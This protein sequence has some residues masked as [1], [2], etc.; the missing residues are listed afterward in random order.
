M[1]VKSVMKTAIRYSPGFITARFCGISSGTRSSS[2]RLVVPGWYD[3]IDNGTDTHKMTAN[4]MYHSLARCRIV[5]D[6][7]GYCDYAHPLF[8][9]YTSGN[10]WVYCTCWWH[11]AKVPGH[12][13]TQCWLNIHCFGPISYRNITVI[14]K[15]IRKRDSILKKYQVFNA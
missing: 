10:A 5:A 13:Y 9:P 12:H 14:G 11:D 3:T 8:N 1:W 4:M 15:Y 6:M 2:C 7:P